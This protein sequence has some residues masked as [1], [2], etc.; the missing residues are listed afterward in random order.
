MSAPV[1][2]VTGATGGIGGATARA[3]AERGWS[4]LATGRARADEVAAALP[5]VDGA[6]HVAVDADLLDPETPRR[7]L[8]TCLTEFGH[9]DGLVNNAGILGDGMIGMIPDRLVDDVLGVN[10]VAPLRLLQVAARPLRRT[11]GS[12]VN[13]TSIMG[14][15]GAATQAL[16]AASKAAVVGMTNSAA[17]ELAPHGVRVNAVAPGFVDSPMTTGLPEQ[18]RSERLG[19]VPMG[20]A[21]TP[22]DVADVVA[23]LLS[24]QARYVTGQVIGVDGGMVL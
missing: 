20:R 17:K 15:R 9:L 13:L 23:F 21:G 22:E 12:V 14:T 5:A 7:L 18:V 2:L 10:V 4:V 16:Y 3:L 1:A 11:Q 19:Q 6:R 8:Q 24:P